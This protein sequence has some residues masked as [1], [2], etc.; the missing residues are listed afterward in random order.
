MGLTT[1]VGGANSA[2]ES[3]MSSF[4][5]TWTSCSA[6][7]PAFWL[8]AP[9]ATLLLIGRSVHTAA[10]TVA[11][12]AV[13]RRA[14]KFS[15]LI[16][17][18][19]LLTPCATEAAFLEFRLICRHFSGSLCLADLANLIGHLE[20]FLFLPASKASWQSLLLIHACA[21][22]SGQGGSELYRDVSPNYL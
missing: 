19:P 5:W 16:A 7:C 14:F 21:Q 6:N 4:V 10:I 11:V 9:A 17:S 12:A 2:P 8:S 18:L 20:Y 22:N 3:T 1:P 15:D 13:R